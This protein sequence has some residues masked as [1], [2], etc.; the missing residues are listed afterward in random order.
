MAALSSHRSNGSLDYCTQPHN[1]ALTAALLAKGVAFIGPGSTRTSAWKLYWRAGV[2]ARVK[3][4]LRNGWMRGLRVPLAALADLATTMSLSEAKAQRI[5]EAKDLNL[6]G[7][8]RK[9]LSC[10]AKL[11]KRDAL[12]KMQEFQRPISSA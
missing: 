8:K 10:K 9:S 7:S 6:T 2:P 5:A 1:S 12:F 11:A 3:H 4:R